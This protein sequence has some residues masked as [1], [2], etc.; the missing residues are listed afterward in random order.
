MWR[1]AIR[2][3]PEEQDQQGN[4][5]PLFD[6]WV[7]ALM[8]EPWLVAFSDFVRKATWA[9]II[10]ATRYKSTQKSTQPITR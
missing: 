9:N 5:S 7:D 6:E 2:D 1:R 3:Y 4:A 8:E 10:V